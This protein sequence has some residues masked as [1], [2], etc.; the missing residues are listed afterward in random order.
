MT[1]EESKPGAPRWHI[2]VNTLEVWANRTLALTVVYVAVLAVL[3]WLGIL[4]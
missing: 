1:K 2:R 4:R 3:A